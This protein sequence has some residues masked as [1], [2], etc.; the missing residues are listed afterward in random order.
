[1]NTIHAYPGCYIVKV[2]QQPQEGINL[3]E[4]K[5]KR[6]LKGEIVDIGPS[7]STKYGG[8]MKPYNGVAVGDTLY[9]LSYEGG[10]DKVSEELYAVIF[11]DSRAWE[12]KI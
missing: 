6:I 8:E 7:L 3:G 5:N 11:E 2:T 12:K 9:F 4:E 10:Y 1:M